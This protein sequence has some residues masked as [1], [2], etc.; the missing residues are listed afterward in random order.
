MKVS[1]LGAVTNINQEDY[2]IYETYYKVLYKYFPQKDVF[3]PEKVDNFL[4]NYEKNHKS[5]DRVTMNSKMVKFDIEQVENSKIII[6]DI[7]H[8]STGL[9]LELAHCK[10]KDICFFAK[11]GT[12]YSNM[13]D[14][15]FPDVPIVRYTTKEDL[16][17]KLNHVVQKYLKFGTFVRHVKKAGC[18]F[19]D[20]KTKKVGLIYRDKQDDYTFPKG[21]LEKGE[22]LPECAIRETAE[23]T[24]RDV[25]LLSKKPFAKFCYIDGVADSSEVEYYLAIDI[26]PSA[27]TSTDTHELV[28]KDYDEVE[29]ILTYDNLKEIWNMVYPKIKDYKEKR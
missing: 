3:T 20:P 10:A 11:E 13:V 5:A 9:G 7:S 6:A 19:F 27:N 18:V 23:E 17:R 21:H 26:G 4:K 25:K 2:A 8:A 1:I 16:E 12:T 15:T 29:N 14:G 24:K 22:T 28:W